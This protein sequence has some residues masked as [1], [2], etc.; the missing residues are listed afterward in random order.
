ML[1][2]MLV[3]F[4]GP[5]GEET[6]QKFLQMGVTDFYPNRNMVPKESWVDW[7]ESAQRSCILLGQA[8][9][10]WIRDDRFEPALVGRLVAGVKIEIFFLNPNTSEAD[11]REKEDQQ[12]RHTK[13]RIKESIRM[14]WEIRGRLNDTEKERLAIYTYAATPSLGVTWVDNWMLVTHYLAGF[15]NLTSPAL[16]VEHGPSSRCP[17]AVYARNVDHIRDNRSKKVNDENVGE[18]IDG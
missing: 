13:A 18:Y 8:H 10:E 5:N 1:A 2:A 11:V 16:R 9:G 7:L 12:K 3:T 17:Y 15:S 6:Y 4:A 14:L